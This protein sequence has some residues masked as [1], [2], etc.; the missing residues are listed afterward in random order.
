MMHL[1]WCWSLQARCRRHRGGAVTRLRAHTA[2]RSGRHDTRAAAA[3]TAKR[4]ITAGRHTWADIVSFADA[5]I[6]D[7]VACGV[8]ICG[9]QLPH[10]WPIRVWSQVVA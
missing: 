4:W 2:G 6:Y 5:Q 1:C 8:P 10:T 7:R 3:H 9:V